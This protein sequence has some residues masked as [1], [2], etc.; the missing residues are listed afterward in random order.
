MWQLIFSQSEYFSI[1]VTQKIGY[2]YDYSDSCNIFRIPENGGTLDE[3]QEQINYNDNQINEKL[4][5]RRWT[6][7]EKMELL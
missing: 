7:D 1:S 3:K 2:H 6:K 4:T 5:G